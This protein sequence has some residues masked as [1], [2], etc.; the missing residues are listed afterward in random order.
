MGMSMFIHKFAFENRTLINSNNCVW[1][2]Q[3]F[4][5]FN[6]KNFD[7]YITKQNKKYIIVRYYAM[8][9]DQFQRTKIFQGSLHIIFVWMEKCQCL[10]GAERWTIW[11]SLNSES[12]KKSYYK[13]WLK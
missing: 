2:G 11:R 7:P 12:K 3:K 10:G 4:F 8:V 5:R 1:Q 13:Q 6:Y 9:I